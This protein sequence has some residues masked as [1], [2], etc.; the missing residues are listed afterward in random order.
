MLRRALAVP[1][2][3][4]V[5]ACTSAAPTARPTTS[6]SPLVS[7]TLPPTAAPTQTQPPSPTPTALPT[8]SAQPTRVPTLAPTAP[9]TVTQPPSD[10]LAVDPI[11]ID[12]HLDAL[13]AIADANDG[14]RAA[15]TPGY[16]ASVDY[17]VQQLEAL[18]LVVELDPVDFTFFREDESA[19]TLTIGAQ[20]WGP[21]WVQPMLYS[22]GGTVSGEVETVAI[23]G[24]APTGASGCDASDWA[25]FEA[26][27]IAL[28]MG[29]GCYARDKVIEAQNAG[30]LAIISLAV[31][32][33][34]GT[35]LQ[36]T[37]IDPSL[38]DIPSL[39]V[40]SEPAAALL[41]A[42]SAG[43]DVILALE[44]DE[45]PVTVDNVI[46]EITGTTDE[47]MMIG[48][49][50]DSVIDGPGIND[51]GSGVAAILAL[52][53]QIAAGPTPARTVRFGFWTAEEFG[54]FG[55][56]SY[57]GKLS[58]VERSQIYAYLNLD[59]VA[60]LNATRYVYMPTGQDTN[61]V[62]AQLTSAF[63]EAFERLD[64]P[65]VAVDLGGGSDHFPFQLAGIPIGGLFSGLSPLTPEEASLFG[66]VAGA[67]ADPCYHLACDSRSNADDDTATLFANATGI[68]LEELIY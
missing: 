49:H 40:G 3:A 66:G 39:L 64:A 34:E 24:G 37:L 46:A 56:H 12:R 20:S 52:V 42:A 9:R 41:D 4:L 44:V 19:R 5:L 60:S 17:V 35:V 21:E 23:A 65:G 55:S 32:A 1:L 29:G 6:P 54:D 51:N 61:E 38:I 28:V 8:T 57:V 2:A 26:G 48:G 68:L 27:N 31:F 25:N 13:Q 43:T 58:D 53:E 62:D 67:P 36:P 16:E 11:T 59:M 50:L 18:G 45:R 14:V 47:V 22:A 7:P 10:G 33:A 30:A 63:L 15:G